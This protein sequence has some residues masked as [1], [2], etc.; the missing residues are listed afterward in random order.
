MKKVSFRQDTCAGGKLSRGGTRS[1]DRLDAT[2]LVRSVMS[3]LSPAEKRVAKVVLS[4]PEKATELPIGELAS[5]SK[6]SEATVVRFSKKAGFDG[7][8]GLRLAL[9]SEAGRAS[10]STG[11]Q[12]IEDLDIAPDDSLSVMMAKVAAADARAVSDTADTLDVAALKKAITA[13]ARGRKTLIVGVGASGLVARDLEQKLERLGLQA[14]AHTDPHSAL[15][16]AALLGPKDVVVGISHT[17]ET[18]DTLE[19]FAL[20]SDAGAATIAI[21]NY[22]RSRLAAL[23]QVLLLTVA[24]ESSLRSGAM[25]SRVAQ[26]SIVDFL[27]IGLVRER[28]EKTRSALNKTRTAVA[29]RKGPGVAKVDRSA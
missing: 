17:G 25:A 23:T 20:A 10:A 18:E 7:Y 13:V 9:A 12:W 2:V 6:T 15:M 1:A 14:R 5:A 16:A 21:T 3:S 11:S 27:C 26:L 4:D 8:P 22:P 24:P 19:P 28:P 29:D